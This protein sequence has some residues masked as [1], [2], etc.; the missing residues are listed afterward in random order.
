MGIRVVHFWVRI[1]K[2]A[3]VGIRVLGE[4]KEDDRCGCMLHGVMHICIYNYLYK[5]SIYRI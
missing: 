2:E 3:D 4:D 1:R 5:I